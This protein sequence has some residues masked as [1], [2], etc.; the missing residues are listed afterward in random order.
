[1][2]AVKDKIIIFGAG[3]IG[4]SFIGQFFSTGGFEIV[5]A[6][7]ALPIINELNRRKKYEVVIKFEEEKIITVHNVRAIDTRNPEL[8][9]KEISEARILAVSVGKN[10]LPGIMIFS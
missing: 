1:M 9:A 7:I 4:R 8:V 10:A 3:K 2:N 5:F 6:D